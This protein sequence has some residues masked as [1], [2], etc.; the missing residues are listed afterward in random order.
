[1]LFRSLGLAFRQQRREMGVSQRSYAELRGWS[2]GRQ[3]RLEATAG[4]LRLEVLLEA[5]DGTGFELVLVRT[6]DSAPSAT[7]HHL[8]GQWAH[9]LDSEFVARD[10]ADR[11][12]PAHREVRRTV[13]PPWWWW[14]LYSTSRCFGPEWTTEE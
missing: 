3:C 10:D 11:R 4:E 6:G 2:K 9:W 5:L 7:P 1:M 12:F 8:T 14:R 13:R